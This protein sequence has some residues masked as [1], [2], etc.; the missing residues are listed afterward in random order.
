VRVDSN[1][2]LLVAASGLKMVEDVIS[3]IRTADAESRPRGGPLG[4]VRTVECRD[5]LDPDPRFEP[6]GVVHSSPRYAAR[7]VIHPAPRIE[8]QELALDRRCRPCE[9]V[10]EKSPTEL[11][12]EPPWKTVPWKNPPPPARKI[13]LTPPH[14]DICHKGR[15][16][17][18]FL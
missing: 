6:H 1:I 9:V 4:P 5:R 14:P 17:D 2:A 10:I 7:P 8:A 18:F 13:K 3:A 12:F 11:P 16:L 15:L